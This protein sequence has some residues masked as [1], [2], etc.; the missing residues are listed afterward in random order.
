MISIDV[1][2]DLMAEYTK[3]MYFSGVRARFCKTFSDILKEIERKTY[4][5][6][7]ADALCRLNVEHQNFNKLFTDVIYC[8]EDT[9]HVFI[10]LAA[11]TIAGGSIMFTT[12]ATYSMFLIF[13][14]FQTNH[15]ISWSYIQ[16]FVILVL[17]MCLFFKYPLVITKDIYIKTFDRRWCGIL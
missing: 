9:Y 3:I 16:S 7:Y 8:T 11:T 6:E 13:L 10:D 4:T 2:V 5:G 12:M 17:I 1:I 14:D 15:D